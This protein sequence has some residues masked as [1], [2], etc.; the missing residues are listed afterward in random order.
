MTTEEI[1]ERL[2]ELQEVL[3]R[4]IELEKE[5]SDIP[6][7]LVSQEELVVRLKETYIQKDKEFVELRKKEADFQNLLH[8]AESER[9]KAEKRMDSIETQREYEALDKEIKDAANKEH[10][11]RHD[12]Q[13]AGQKVVTFREELT[14][15][16]ELMDGQENELAERRRNIETEIA[17]RQNQ[18]K[19]IAEEESR[20]TPGMDEELVFK[21]ERIIRKKSGH[22]I[23]AVRGGVCNSCH[24]IL[25][26]QFAN[27]VRL[28]TEVL[29]CPYCSSILYHEDAQEGEDFFDENTAG[30]LADLEDNDEEDI[31]EDADDEDFD[32]KVGAD[33]EE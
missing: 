29:S 31:D 16:K 28:G 12:M 6:K 7:S 4:K 3:K 2:R 27:S 10:N 21:F 23:V 20:L 25:P 24:M 15:H 32:E 5:I 1:F 26:V 17:D 22:G 30:S 19:K 8:L 13:A 11:Y 33:F 18:L 14:R 9:E